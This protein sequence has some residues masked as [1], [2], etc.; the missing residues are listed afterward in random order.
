[1]GSSPGLKLEKHQC[2]ENEMVLAENQ[3][4][5]NLGLQGKSNWTGFEPVTYY[6]LVPRSNHWANG[7][8]WLLEI[9]RSYT[10][11]YNNENDAKL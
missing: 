10:T 4:G 5:E 9:L 7:N 1:M 3:N 11:K 2:V 6:I 8:W